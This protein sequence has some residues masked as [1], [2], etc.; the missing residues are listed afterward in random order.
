MKKLI[1][2][3]FLLLI[4]ALFII[5]IFF[6]MKI[7]YNELINYDNIETIS[8]I[9]KILEDKINNSNILLVGISDKNNS[10]MNTYETIND[11]NINTSETLKENNYIN[12]KFFYNQ[13]SERQ[14]L[15]YNGLYD[16]K[17]KLRQGDYI[18]NYE[19]KFS[20][21]LAQTDGSRILGVDYQTAIEAFIQEN[22]DMFYLDINKMF[23]NIETTT[24]LFNTKYKVFIGT[25]DGIKYYTDDY[26]NV[27]EIE[28]AIDEIE[29]EK[30]KILSKL[31]G[32]DYKKIKYIHDYLINNVEYDSSY[33]VV[34]AYNI[35]GALVKKKCVCE[36]YAKAFKYLANSVGIECELVQGIGRNNSGKQEN[37]EWNCVKLNGIWY[38]ID[39]TW[40]D[41]IVIGGNGKATSEMKYKYFLKGSN[42]FDKDHMVSNQFSEG[43]KLFAYPSVS[44]KDCNI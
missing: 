10:K 37:H 39:C 2:N 34:G 12:T 35:Y 31:D 14:K 3:L 23:L 32:T 17:E 11:N 27:T 40:D 36:G 42:T 18:I 44:V 22:P 26:S 30:E 15:I 9:P 6:L 13:L 16:N 24:K 25:K 7:I 20:D 43:G 21:I 5:G 4:M 1:K 41:P 19:N 38:Y 8:D 28:K 29:K 33:K